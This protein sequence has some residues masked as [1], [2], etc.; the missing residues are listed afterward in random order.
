M[1]YSIIVFKVQNLYTVTLWLLPLQ[2]WKKLFLQSSVL[3]VCVCVCLYTNHYQKKLRQHS[4]SFPSETA[5]FTVHMMHKIVHHASCSY[6]SCSS[7]SPI[8]SSETGLVC[9]VF[10]NLHICIMLTFLIK[11]VFPILLSLGMQSMVAQ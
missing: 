3:C 9:M 6:C 2:K 8:L 4:D 7:T 5:N 1:E 11:L 10:V